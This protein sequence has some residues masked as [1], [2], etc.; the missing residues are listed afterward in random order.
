VK[1]AVAHCRRSASALIALA[2]LL[3]VTSGIRAADTVTA[4]GLFLD[5]QNLEKDNKFPR[6]IEQYERFLREFP[7]H[8]Q[9]SEVRYRLGRCYDNV[10]R[11]DD[12]IANLRKATQTGASRFRSRADALFLLGKLLGAAERHD[13][14]VVALD[15]LLSEGAGLYEDE[16]LNLCGS[17]YA[18]L[19]KYDEAAAKLNVL[20][21]HTGSPFAEEAAQKLAMIWLKSGQIDLAIE[22]VRDLASRYPNNA[23]ARE[24]MI[25]LADAFRQQKR[26]DQAI[27]LCEQVR[28]SFPGSREAA[29]STV[30]RGLVHRDRKEYDK[31]ATLLETAARHPDV[32]STSLGP[33]A[34]VAAAGLYFTELGNTNKAMDLYGETV[35]MAR[36]ASADDTQRILE[37][38]YVRLA[39]HVF[40]QRKWAEALNYYNLL[41]DLDSKLYVLPRIAACQAELGMGLNL[42][43][44]EGPELA[45]ITN[46]I[47]RTPGTYAAAEGETFLADREFSKINSADAFR[48]QIGV[49]ESIR[50]RYPATVLAEHNLNDYLQLQIGRCLMRVYDVERRA[51]PAAESWKPAIAALESLATNTNSPYRQDALEHAAAIADNAGQFDRSFSVYRDLYEMMVQRLQA[52]TNDQRASG[53]KIEYLKAMLTRAEKDASIEEAIG[54]ARQI[55]EKEGVASPD[56]REAQYYVAELQFFRRK[57]PAAAD[58][59]AAF[60]KTYGPRQNDKGDLETGP[61]R[62]ATP[63]AVMRRVCEAS[64]RIAHC[65]YMNGDEPK[66][67]AA[68]DWMVRNLPA[69][70]PWV[71]EGWYWILMAKASDDATLGKES[72]RK[73]GEA[74]WQNIVHP[75]LDLTQKDFSKGYHPWL[76]A[77]EADRYV[78]GAIVNAGLFFSQ[79]GD[80]T[81][82]AAIFQAYLDLYPEGRNDKQYAT[83]RYMLGLEYI[84]LNLPDK[85]IEAWKPYV[86]T[87]RDDRYRVSALRQLGYYA[88]KREDFETAVEAYGAVIDEYGENPVDAAGRAIPTP[89]S[90][91]T[92]KRVY[93]WDG[94]RMKPPDGLDLGETR[95]ALGFLYWQQKDYESCARALAP[96][97]NDRS[98]AR[99]KSMGKALF[100]AGQS[101]FKLF[102]YAR[103]APFLLKLIREYPDYENI[104][105]VFVKTALS[106][107]ES[108][109]WADIVE[110]HKQF[111]QRFRQSV[112]RAHMDVYRA[113]AILHVGAPQEGRDLLEQTLRSDTF[114]D[115]KANAAYYLGVDVLRWAMP[116]YPEAL[117]FFEKSL[118]Y[119]PTARA[120]L[121]AARCWAKLK[122]WKKAEAY[123]ERVLRDFPDDS[124][125]IR[126]D[127]ERVRM[128]ARDE[129]GAK[130]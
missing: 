69:H 55:V 130:K 44:K 29:A 7:E 3:C 67:L 77:K 33:E 121:E 62:P 53:D 27:A 31:A 57:Y 112:R 41:R 48:K 4:E 126:R 84:D 15:K 86:T 23:S 94:I 56:A 104:E 78:R 38:C 97:V 95:F 40:A 16:A 98:L 47:A 17:Y 10:G 9:A 39:E 19:K 109:K 103:G 76:R 65:W 81:K 21:N 52:D 120:C 129:F 64:V 58:A 108:G 119:E 93:G 128:Q 117:K 18:V 88:F 35:S 106:C 51:N 49:Y 63:N 12:A 28:T 8:S 123:A 85:L 80:H 5:A 72:R 42:N 124:P 30:V 82:A 110:L 99:S 46:A 14:A 118:E 68:Y 50:K 122:D 101:Y 89:E 61:W 37:E 114:R 36:D 102:D 91:W 20:K 107:A 75:S 26:Y 2:A 24:V 105:E 22:A 6:A 113:A 66:M 79:S 100:M 90:E 71:A 73:L 54:L 92:R 60:I 43:L 127:A 83:A 59:F 34:M 87:L 13:E 25:Q 70:N 1:Q 116:E 125:V 45:L 111:V 115:V 11:L 74:L 96:F 32:K